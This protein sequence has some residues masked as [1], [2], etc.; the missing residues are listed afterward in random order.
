MNELL[1][2]YNHSK[3]V[4]QGIVGHNGKFPICLSVAK[5]LLHKCF[6][7][8]LKKA[9]KAQ[10]QF[11]A[12]L[13]LPWVSFALSPHRNTAA[14]VENRGHDLLLSATR[15]GKGAGAE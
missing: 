13:V 7:Q 10:E 8:A 11:R 1:N 5:C 3:I 12:F 6:F 15:S 9:P 2:W 14:A 4:S